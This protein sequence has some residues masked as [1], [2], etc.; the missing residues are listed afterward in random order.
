MAI[1]T[2]PA[3]I[4]TFVNVILTYITVYFIRDAATVINYQF[5]SVQNI[6]AV[7]VGLAAVTAYAIREGAKQRELEREKERQER[8]LE[9]EK[10]REFERKM[11]FYRWANYFMSLIP[12]IVNT[13]IVFSQI[14]A[15][16]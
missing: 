11:R 1:T 16:N 10:D 13:L 9:R 7:E 2:S 12:M 6:I 8:E 4:K 5:N 15:D 3:E 14:R